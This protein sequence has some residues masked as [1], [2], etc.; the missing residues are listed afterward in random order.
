M[1]TSRRWHIS[2]YPPLTLRK[3]RRYN[4]ASLWELVPLEMLVKQLEG[5]TRRYCHVFY[6]VSKFMSTWVVKT[7][8]LSLIELPNF[9]SIQN[10]YR[11]WSSGTQDLTESFLVKTNIYQH[12]LTSWSL[13]QSPTN[14]PT[15]TQWT[16]LLKEFAGNVMEMQ[17]DSKF[18][19]SNLGLLEHFVTKYSQHEI[20]GYRIITSEFVS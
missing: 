15:F 9:F 1:K 7:L 17:L 12:V 18:T 14:N 20:R 3:F 10:H 13:I 19:V 2:C 4:K 16:I 5:L 6:N 11:N 8:A